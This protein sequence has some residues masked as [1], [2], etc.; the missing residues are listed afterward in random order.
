MYGIS[1]HYYSKLL[2]N[3]GPAASQ[4]ITESQNHGLKKTRTS[5]VSEFCEKLHAILFDKFKNLDY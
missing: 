5:K 1:Y 4:V 2:P 3:P